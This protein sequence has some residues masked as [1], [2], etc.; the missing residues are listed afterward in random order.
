MSKL[1]LTTLLILLTLYPVYGQEVF[2]LWS[3]EIP[4]SKFSDENELKEMSEVG[5]LRVENV[6]TPTITYYPA[7]KELSTGQAIIICPGGG[8]FIEAMNIEGTDVAEWLNSIG[9]SAFVLKYRLPKSKNVVVGYKAPLQDLQRAVRLVRS[10]SEAYGISPNSI[11]VMGFSAGGHLAATG[12]TRFDSGDSLA[13][14]PV[15]KYSCRPDF[16][17][18]LYPVITFKE[19]FA[20]IGSRDNLL[21]EY[22]TSKLQD[23]FSNELHVNK[24]TPPTLL[25]HCSDDSA[26]PVQNSLLFYEAL[27]NNGIDTELHIYNRGGHGFGLGKP[28]SNVITWKNLCANWLLKQGKKIKSF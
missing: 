15:G 20:H 17:I 23:Y 5:V 2:E 13:I 16:S 22:R 9:V 12:T 28:E 14:D 18:L 21:G 3:H 10:N 4:N 11:G 26:V 1:L 6:K 25:F 24:N 7:S 8:Y 27:L 19:P